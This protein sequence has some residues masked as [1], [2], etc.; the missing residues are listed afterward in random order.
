MSAKQYPFPDGFLW[1]TATA[2]AQVEGAAYEDGR[3]P[4]IWDVFT[5]RPELHLDTPDIACDAYHRWPE[6]VALMKSLGIQAYRFSFSWSRIL[7]EGIGKVNASAIAYYRSLIQA[8]KQAG[9]K[10]C[11]TIYHWDLPHALQTMGGF[12]N[13]EFIHW[14]LEYAKVLWDNFGDDVDMW[15]TFNEPIAIYVGHALG[16]F[17]PGL[18]NEEYARQC[19]HHLLVAHGEA[20]RLF[21]SYHFSKAQIGITVDI[22]HH[23]P[24]RPDN[25]ED[26]LL[27]E[28]QNET[29]GYGMFLNPIFLGGYSKRTV[30]YLQKKDI[31]PEIKSGDFA[32]IRQPLDFYGLNFYNAIYDRADQPVL[33]TGNHG[34]NFQTSVREGWDYDALFD[35]LNLLKDKYHLQIPI[36]ITENGMPGSMETPDENGVVH[37][38]DRIDYLTNILQRLSQAI[39]GGADVRGYFLWS[40]LDN[41]EWSMGYQIRYGI[42][43]T[44]YET[45]TRTPKDSARWYS[46]VIRDNAVTVEEK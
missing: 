5:H 37:D 39:Q 35:V 20:V 38:A 31:Y 40:L 12:G 36:Y 33:L 46:A 10:A 22:W 11:A 29:Q 14:Y 26:V 18:R 6:D 41:F 32:T 17:A 25:P 45:L 4:S 28:L 8:L 3:G 2:A 21:R 34:G 42:C 15:I 23:Y 9:I 24:D 7:P 43:R 27:A 30:E 16:F 13:R 44:D 19:I 1:G